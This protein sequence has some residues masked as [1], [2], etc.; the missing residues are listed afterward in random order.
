M[1]EMMTFFVGRIAPFFSFLGSCVIVPGVS[2]LGFL[3]A[4]LVIGV[5]LHNFL[6]VGRS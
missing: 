5:L 4:M 3:G 1:A 2:L 6:P